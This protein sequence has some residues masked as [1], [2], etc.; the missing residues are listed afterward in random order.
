MQASGERTAQHLHLELRLLTSGCVSCGRSARHS[1]NR[2]ASQCVRQLSAIQSVVFY[3]NL[4]VMQAAGHSVS[5]SA[6]DAGTVRQSASQS[7]S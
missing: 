1:G 7:V 4:V 6:S 5:Q 2:S 3:S